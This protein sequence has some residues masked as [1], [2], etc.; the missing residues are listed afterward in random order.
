MQFRLYSALIREPAWGRGSPG[1]SHQLFGKS[2]VSKIPSVFAK[3]S[4]KNK[5][6]LAGSHTV[7]ENNSKS[8]NL[9]ELREIFREAEFLLLFNHKIILLK[10]DF[11]SYFM[12]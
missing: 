2:W 6:K 11:P 4:G 9:R 8:L 12:K 10:L 1:W 5:H 3:K 7:F